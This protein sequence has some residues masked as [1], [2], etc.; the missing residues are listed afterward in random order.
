LTFKPTSRPVVSG[1]WLTVVMNGERR[2]FEAGMPSS[3]CIIVLLPAMTALTTCSGVTLPSGNFTRLQASS[4]RLF[5]VPS[6]R[7]RRS[8][9][10]SFLP[11]YMMREI[12][13][14]PRAI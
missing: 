5:I 8:S 11:A 1:G 6:T 7:V 13:S 9:L 10:P 14:S 12:T 4:S 3:R 2:M